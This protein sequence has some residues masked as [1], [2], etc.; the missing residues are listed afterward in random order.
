MAALV[1]HLRFQYLGGKQIHRYDGSKLHLRGIKE[2][3][4]LAYLVMESRQ[5]HS[6]EAIMG[7]FWPEMPQAQARNNLRVTLARIRKN[8]GDD[9]EGR[10]FLHSTRREIAFNQRGDY[11]LDV[12]AFQSDIQRVR[13]HQ[14]QGDTA[15]TDCLKV[16]SHAVAL[17]KGEFMA[18]FHV[19]GCAAFDEWLLVQREHLHIQAMELLEQLA[20]FSAQTGDYKSAEVFARRQIE[21]DPLQENAHR[22]LIQVFCVQGQRSAALT[23]FEKCRQILWEELGVEPENETALLHNQILAGEIDSGSGPRPPAGTPPIPSRAEPAPAPHN[24]PESLTPFIGREHELEQMG[25]RLTE[26]DYRIITIVGPGGIGKSRLAMQIA[27]ENLHLFSD[28]VYFIPLA[29]VQAVE[30]IPA[31]IADALEIAFSN[32]EQS[33]QEQLLEALRSRKLLLILDNMEHLL[34]SVDLLLDIIR[35]A[36]EV[37]LLLTSRERL[38]IQSEDL[39]HLRGLPVPVLSELEHAS[40]FAAVRL[41]TDRAYRLHKSFKL[42]P[43]NVEP[44]IRICRLL[45]GAPLAIELAASWIRDHSC[46]ELADA[47]TQNLD[48]LA[49][50]YRDLPP[51]HR[52]MRAIFDHSWHLLGTTQQTLLAS[53]SVFR[54]GLSTEAADSIA[55]ATPV[56]L[57]SLSFKSLLHNAGSGRYDMHELIRQFAEERLASLLPDHDLVLD[58]HSRYYLEMVTRQNHRLRGSSPIEASA[59]L[60]TDIDNIRTAWTRAVERGFVAELEA[61]RARPSKHPPSC[62]TAVTPSPTR[63][64]S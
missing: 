57:T 59:R 46:E 33:S 6:R 18:G 29:A 12:S 64:R 40:R 41:F 62:S 52:S 30:Q 49:V 15:C 35:Q 37:T 45:A 54:G 23:A 24:L 27:R 16:M 53:L 26:G 1:N 21:L 50:T 22:Q 9:Q 39:Y 7:L 43:E 4:L 56:A 58:K 19:P 11:W 17:Y 3:G 38:D 32:P 28:G 20:H 2:Q 10:P 42:T 25:R 51:R 55:G 34:T 63:S 47:I 8:I 14:H 61:S 60:H 36:P 48:L 44:I 31:A 13:K 5:A